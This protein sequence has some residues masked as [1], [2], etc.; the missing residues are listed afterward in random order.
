MGP[1]LALKKKKVHSM[2][3]QG[4]NS[5]VLCHRMIIIF[6]NTKI[7]AHHDTAQYNYLTKIVRQDTRVALN[8]TIGHLKPQWINDPF[9]E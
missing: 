5:I 8:H 2:S 1:M 7:T 3:E 9:I 6:S 4:G